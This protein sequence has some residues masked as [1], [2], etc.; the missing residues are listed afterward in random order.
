MTI[1]KATNI[2]LFSI[3]LSFLSCVQEAHV[4]ALKIVAG[5]SKLTGSIIP[6]N[7]QSKDSIVVNISVLHPISG[8]NISYKVFTDQAGKFSLDLDVETDTSY[9]SLYTSVAL[10][11]SLMLKMINGGVTNIDMIYDSNQDFKHIEATP[12]MNKY[13]MRQSNEVISKMI[14]YQPEKPD[15]WV[16]PSH[17]D[18][19]PNEF[20]KSVK[21][22]L[23]KTLTLFVDNDNLFSNE[24]KSLISKDFLL[25]MYSGHIFDYEGEMKRNYHNATQDRD[26]E[27]EIQQIDKSYFSF[28]KDFN[29]NDPQY[30]QVYAFPE[31]QHKILQNEVLDLPVIGDIDIASWLEKVKGVLADL[32]G[33]DEGPYYDVLVANAYGRQL[34]EEVRP[35]SEKQKENITHYWGDGEIPKI[36]FRKNEQVV[37]LDKVKSAVVV[38]DVSSVSEDKVMETIISKYK[39]KVVFIDFWATWCGPCLDAMKEFRGVKGEF[40][41]KDVVFVYIT[42]GSSP[43]KLWDEKIKGIGSEH[44][45]LSDDQWNYLMDHFGFEGIPSYV[46]YNKEGKLIKKFTG[47]PGNDAVKSM[48]EDLL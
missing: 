45:Y 37:E 42:N 11:K 32:I 46:L 24:L 36:L 18:K 26:G 47:F 27:P 43:Q 8:E 5:S 4:D 21:R 16:Y 44:Y 7:G 13:D 6:P 30:L 39:D 31:F 22:T 33:F 40:V 9:I 29:L 28:L 12:D 48:I 23:S 17:Y 38:N 35:L 1:R 20:L 14:T 19:S 2:L 3:L 15:D 34:N 10:Y 25:F 41:D